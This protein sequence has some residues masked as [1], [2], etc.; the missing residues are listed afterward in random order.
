MNNTDVG[1]D[2]LLVAA[3]HI[4]Y[5]YNDMLERIQRMLKEKDPTPSDAKKKDEDPYVVKLGTTKTA[6]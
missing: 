6:W 5:N 4:E 1:K 2:T 3:G